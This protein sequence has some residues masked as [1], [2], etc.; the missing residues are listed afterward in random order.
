MNS[1]KTE[2]NPSPEDRR[3]KKT[4][5]IG[6]A[7]VGILVGGSIWG[8]SLSAASTSPSAVDAT[9]AGAAPPPPAA[10]PTPHA[11]KAAPGT[12]AAPAPSTTGKAAAPAPSATGEAAAKGKS[13]AELAATPQLVSA[14]V[15][16]TDSASLRPGVTAT[17]AGLRAVAGEAV[18]PG[19]IAGPAIRFTVTVTNHSAQA[20][21]LENAFIH[22]EG[23]AKRVPALQLSGPGATRF[24]ASVDAGA[25][26]SAVFVFSLPLDQRDHVQIYLNHQVSSPIA[27]FTGAVPT[28]GGKS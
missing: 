15:A 14:P 4:L 10:T 1:T 22:V 2:G 26:A 23:G 8:S 24:P 6:L 20:L 7:L 3:R 27:A 18:V 5:A 21:S 17:I 28:S 16:F 9:Q 25:A 19:D 12:A 11:N 13:E